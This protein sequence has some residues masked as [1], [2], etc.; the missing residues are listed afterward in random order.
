MNRWMVDGQMGGYMNGWMDG[1]T[2]RWIDGQ[3]DE[4]MDGWVDEEG[5]KTEPL[6]SSLWLHF[7][8]GQS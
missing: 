1:W 6:L 5:K 8:P 3:M 7:H 2:D 4:P